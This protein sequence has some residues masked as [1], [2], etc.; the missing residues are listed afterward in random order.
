L[1]E[2]GLTEIDAEEAILN[3]RIRRSWPKEHK[4]E[5]TGMSSDGTPIGVV[6][7]ITATNKLRIITAYEDKKK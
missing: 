4:Y 3:G 5:I 2:D 1:D 6:S 7:R